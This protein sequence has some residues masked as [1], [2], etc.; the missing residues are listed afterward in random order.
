MDTTSARQRVTRNSAAAVESTAILVVSCDRYRDVWGPFFTLFWRYWPDCPYPV[1]LGA[2]QE[3]YPDP[4]VQTILVGPDLKWSPGLLKM[5]RDLPRPDLLYLQEDF[6]LSGPVDTAWVKDLIAYAKAKKAGCLRLMPIPGA[7]HPCPDRDDVGELPKGSQYRVSMQAAWWEK[8]VLS[9][10]IQEQ[11]P[12][13]QFE[14]QASRRSVELPEAFLS[15]RE[16]KGYPLNYFTTAVV[17]GRWEPAAVRFCRR[18]GIRVDLQARPM[19]P[20]SYRLRRALRS[21]GVPL[22]IVRI[23]T[24]PFRG[25]PELGMVATHSR[26]GGSDHA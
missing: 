9:S 7:S 17:R 8:R 26:E 22:P 11:E 13:V 20:I 10:L 16:G 19:L 24:L 3:V 5:L 18:E 6:L 2:N 15:L 12:M 21:W 1:Y 23:V 4:K 14:V 25:G